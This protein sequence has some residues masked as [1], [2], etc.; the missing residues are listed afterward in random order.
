MDFTVPVGIGN[1]TG[2]TEYHKEFLPS[3]I[4]TPVE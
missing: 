1:A 4:N 2:K 3:L